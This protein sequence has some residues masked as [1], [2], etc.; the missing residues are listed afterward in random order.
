MTALPEDLS[1]IP[2]P[3]WRLRNIYNFGSRELTPLTS[4]GVQACAWCTYRHA[5][6]TPY[7]YNNIITFKI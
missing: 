3:K 7:T 5:G 6:K 4:K 1:S 2:G